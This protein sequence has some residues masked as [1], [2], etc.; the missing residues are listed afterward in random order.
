ML[1]QQPAVNGTHFKPACKACQMLQFDGVR[2]AD[3]VQREC[4]GLDGRGCDRVESDVL[5]SRASSQAGALTPHLPLSAALSLLSK[6]HLASPCYSP[7]ASSNSGRAS[8]QQL[9]RPIVAR[10]LE[11]LPSFGKA[12]SFDTEGLHS[13]QDLNDDACSD[14]ISC[15]SC[16]SLQLQ[17][18]QQRPASA[19][20]MRQRPRSLTSNGPAHQAGASKHAHAAPADHAPAD[21]DEGVSSSTAALTHARSGDGWSS[22]ELQQQGHA[23]GQG[24][25]RTPAACSSPGRLWCPGSAVRSLSF[26]TAESTGSAPTPSPT[27]A[28]AHA[29]SSAGKAAGQ[30]AAAGADAVAAG[31]ARRGVFVGNLPGDVGERALV[32]L[33]SRCGRIDSLWIARNAANQASLGYGFVVFD[34]SSGQQATERAERELNGLLLQQQRICVRV[35]TRSF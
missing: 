20:S 19:A 1:L 32:E 8:D 26:Q 34:A 23:A 16:S 29:R 15:C 25:P 22:V 28:A 13:V 3:A 11:S 12:W 5:S 7:R 10:F 2:A 27:T 17:H 4:D 35:S 30:H 21:A 18:T 9:L 6:Q 14:S 24:A 33:F 31:S